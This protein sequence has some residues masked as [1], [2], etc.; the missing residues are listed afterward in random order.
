M[1]TCSEACPGI[2]ADAERRSRCGQGLERL[3]PPVTVVLGAVRRVFLC[4]GVDQTLQKAFREVRVG[5][6]AHHTVGNTQI[7]LSS[8]GNDDERI[9]SAQV[10]TIHSVRCEPAPRQDHAMHIGGM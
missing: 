4:R 10:A 2:K 5:V 3:R 8:G 6:N 7:D 9:S 1:N